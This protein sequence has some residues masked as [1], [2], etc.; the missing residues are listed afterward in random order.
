MLSVL[1]HYSLKQNP[2][3]QEEW[4][5]FHDYQQTLIGYKSGRM[6]VFYSPENLLDD[7]RII[8]EYALDRHIK[9]QSQQ[10]L[11]LGYVLR[12]TP[13]M[14]VDQTGIYNLPTCKEGIVLLRNSPKIHL[15]DL[16]ETLN[17]KTIIADGSNF[18]SFVRHWGKTAKDMGVDFHSTA[19]EGAWIFNF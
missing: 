19:T 6:A 17:P 4:V 9:K 7:S 3:S 18:P 8:E 13:F 2:H 1:L 12:N 10:V 15:V 16:I 14:I 11:G 5:V